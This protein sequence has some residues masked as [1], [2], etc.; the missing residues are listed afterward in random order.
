[1]GAGKE[2]DVFG[3]APNVAARVQ[4]AADPN[5]VLITAATH[6]LLAGLFVVEDRGA[7]SRELNSRCNFTG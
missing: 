4:A 5:T 2:A 6:R 1:M 3:E 7:R